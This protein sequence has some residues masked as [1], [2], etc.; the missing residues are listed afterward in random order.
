MN[1]FIMTIHIHMY[2]HVSILLWEHTSLNRGQSLWHHIFFSQ[3]IRALQENGCDLKQLCNSDRGVTRM[4]EDI[5]ADLNGWAQYMQ[6]DILAEEWA[7]IMAWIYFRTLLFPW[8]DSVAGDASSHLKIF[9]AYM[10]S[11]QLISNQISEGNMLDYRS[12]LKLD[13]RL[14]LHLLD[15]L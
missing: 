1:H 10:S 4:S 13:P 8:Y 5:Y 9:R 15:I 12:H 7:M 3:R 11:Q 2:I 6:S 14:D